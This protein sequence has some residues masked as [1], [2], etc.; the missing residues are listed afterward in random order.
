MEDKEGAL[1]FII[2]NDKKGFSLTPESEQFLNSLED[3]K[4]AVICVVGKYRTGKSFLVNRVLLN[5]V[6]EGFNVGSTI[7]ACTKVINEDK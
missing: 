4:L 5:K 6:N 1:P 3:T 7:N 2:F